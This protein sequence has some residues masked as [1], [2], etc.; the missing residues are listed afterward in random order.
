MGL[1]PMDLELENRRAFVAGSSSGIGAGI[2][3]G[4][5]REGCEVIVHGRRQE[6]ADEVVAKIRA[7]GGKAMTII[8]DLS[9]MASVDEFAARALEPGPS[10]LRVF[11]SRAPRARRVRRADGRLASAIPDLGRV[12]GAVDPR[13]G[14]GDDG[15]RVGA[16]A[17]LE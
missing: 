7:A 14:A 3:V 9:D 16:G 15:A 12:F 11:P 17:K 10:S 8:G 5:A 1:V 2:A 6:R 13:Y 4:L